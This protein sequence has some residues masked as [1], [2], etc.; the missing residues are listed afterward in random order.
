MEGNGMNNRILFVIICAVLIIFPGTGLARTSFSVP[1]LNG[2]WNMYSTDV[3]QFPS[4]A[5][6]SSYGTI[7]VQ[8]GTITGGT[9]TFPDG[10]SATVNGGF[11]TMDQYGNYSGSASADYGG[12]EIT[13]TFPSGKLD[14]SKTK[15]VSVSMGND[16][17]LSLNTFF[18]E[19]GTFQVSDIAGTWHFYCTVT[20]FNP[21]EVYWMTGTVTLDDSG[22]VMPGGSIVVYNGFELAIV[23]GSIILNEDGTFDP[24]NSFLIIDSISPTGTD[25]ILFGSGKLDQNKTSGS[26]VSYIFNDHLAVPPVDLISLANIYFIKETPSFDTAELAGDWYMF[27]MTTY[28]QPAPLVAW[29]YGVITIDSQGQ[30]T[31]GY[32]VFPD[33]SRATVTGG[34]VMIDGAG[35][36]SGTAMVDYL[37]SASSF[38]IPSGRIDQ[39]KTSGAFVSIGSDNSLS[40]V[41]TVKGV[42]KFPWPMFLPA[43]TNNATP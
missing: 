36:F 25:I 33:G 27:S 4:P 10:T 40:K 32:Y 22:N 13:F 28:T 30:V 37:G 29:D 31:D 42:P 17:S 3:L 8:N 19:G 34:T 43:I 11:F 38:T 21:P 23:S 16:G 2:T 35:N 20:D 12:Q 9:Y 18:K 15:G 1:D 5:V 14:Q 7:T 26:S 41:L 24:Q 39:G 6:V